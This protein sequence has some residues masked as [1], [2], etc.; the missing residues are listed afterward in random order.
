MEEI[1]MLTST[2]PRR[3]LTASF[4]VFIQNVKRQAEEAGILSGTYFVCGSPP[5]NFAKVRA[6]IGKAILGY[7]AATKH[8]PTALPHVLLKAGRR[9]WKV[10]KV[11][12]AGDDITGF[13]PFPPKWEGEAEE[14]LR[15]LIT[16]ALESKIR[17]LQNA[18]TAKPWILLLLDAHNYCDP[19]AWLRAA[20]GIRAVGEFHGIVLI[21]DAGTSHVLHSEDCTLT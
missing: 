17:K 15:R 13:M 2:F 1:I 9:V 14:D 6:D 5:D 3:A 4:R 8:L 21:D 10:E 7:V 11:A 12:S 16:S 18:N 20:A 19:Q